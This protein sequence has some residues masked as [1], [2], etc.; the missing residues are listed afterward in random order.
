MKNKQSIIALLLA[1][2]AGFAGGAF[3]TFFCSS[4]ASQK[5][6]GRTRVIRAQKIEIVDQSNKVRASLEVDTEAGVTISGLRLYDPDERERILLGVT[7]GGDKPYVFPGL[8]FHDYNS[9]GERLASKI[10]AVLLDD[11]SPSLVLRD[12]KGIDRAVIGRSSLEMAPMGTT[13]PPITKWLVLYD[14]EGKV[15][16]KAP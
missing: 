11:G 6:F 15:V 8:S 16:W 12:E 5:I 13:Q 4:T 7:S 1:V 3:W 9:K 10:A 14:K 2:V